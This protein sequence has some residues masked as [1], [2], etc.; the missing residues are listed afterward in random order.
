MDLLSGIM[1]SDKEQAPSARSA[2]NASARLEPR[3]LTGEEFDQIDSQVRAARSW[4][5]SG[6]SGAGRATRSRR[7]WPSW[8]MSMRAAR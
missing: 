1:G 4:S 8:P 2:A 3:H 6:P 5:I 7:Q